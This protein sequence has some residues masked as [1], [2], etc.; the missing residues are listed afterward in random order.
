MSSKRSLKPDSGLHVRVALADIHAEP[1]FNSERVTQALWGTKVRIDGKPEGDYIRIK[2]PDNYPGFIHTAHLSNEELPK[3]N[4][5]ISAGYTP[6]FSSPRKNARIVFGLHFNTEL[7][8]L[9]TKGNWS[10]VELNDDNRG[11]IPADSC[12]LSYEPL[13]ADQKIVGI[14]RRAKAFIGT[15]YVWG[16]ITPSGWDCSGFIK[17][18]FEHYGIEFPRDTKD[19]LRKGSSVK[20]GNHRPGDLIFFNRHVGLVTGEN[21]MIHSSLRRGGVFIDR[22]AEDA[23]E[24]GRQLYNRIKSIKRIS[25]K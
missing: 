24:F 19:Q 15:P 12:I 8:R 20:Y 25:F 11:W 7:R 18:V 13:A 23:D 1:V 2:L 6:V 5:K 16:G 4:T 14:I 22:I 10:E 3:P 21:E 9:S 17:A